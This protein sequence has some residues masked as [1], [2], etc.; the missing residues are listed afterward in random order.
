[1]IRTMLLALA[2]AA[3]ATA[4]A[5]KGAT[6]APVPPDRQGTQPGAL[7]APMPYEASRAIDQADA[8]KTIELSLGATFVVQLVGVPTAGYLWK[9][10]DPPA[11]L[12]V[13][14]VT[15]GP[16]SAAQKQPGFTGG[17]HW[18]VFQ[19]TAD[20]PGKAKLRFEQRRPWESSEPPA[21]TFEVT[22]VVK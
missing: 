12:K 1:M 8:G 11:F 4:C 20:K 13:G 10:V 3:A 16:T 9:P 21:D 14:P 6:P 2:V 22:I 18:E 5:P 17:N 7:P 15:G 19:F